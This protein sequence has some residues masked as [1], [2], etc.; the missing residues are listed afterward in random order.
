MNRLYLSCVALL[1][2]KGAAA[3][4]RTDTIKCYVQVMIPAD[5]AL[6]ISK[7]IENNQVYMNGGMLIYTK[8]Y[9]IMEGGKY[10]K[11][12]SPRR[13]EL[14]DIWTPDDKPVI[15]KKDW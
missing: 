3:Q 13:K 6:G 8:A 7:Q 2:C 5:G 14:K 9:A 4:Q 1:L 12:L 15:M 10:V 11:F